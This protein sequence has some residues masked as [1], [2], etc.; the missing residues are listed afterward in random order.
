MKLHELLSKIH[1]HENIL[2]QH[3][4]KAD[5]EDLKAKAA[6]AVSFISMF[7]EGRH[8]EAVA[9]TDLEAVERGLDRLQTVVSLAHG[10]LSSPET[11]KEPAKTQAKKTVARDPDGNALKTTAKKS[12]VTKH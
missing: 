10:F 9:R 8:L 5:K 1:H 3:F 12:V 2:R 7:P 4:K 6:E 11:E